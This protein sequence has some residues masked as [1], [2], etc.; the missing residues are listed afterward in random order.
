MT[1]E[2]AFLSN[3]G[4][5][6]LSFANLDGGQIESSLTSSRKDLSLFRLRAQEP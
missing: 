6:A 4:V 3:D 1:M 2:G 5:T